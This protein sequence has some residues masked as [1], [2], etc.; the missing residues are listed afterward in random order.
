MA[1]VDSEQ[2]WRLHSHKRSFAA[3][4]VDSDPSSPDP[5]EDL[6]TLT[7]PTPH[8]AV[9]TDHKSSVPP[10]TILTP[11]ETAIICREPPCN[12]NPPAFADLAAYELHV[13]QA[14]ALRCIECS[15]HFPSERILAI[16]LEERHDPFAESQ[17]AKR[18]YKVSQLRFGGLMVV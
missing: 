14:H 18:T 4:E 7:P 11:S 5:E 6:F 8:K 10:S 9:R 17:R 3:T 13:R 15:M 16:H 12:R 1:W 2:M